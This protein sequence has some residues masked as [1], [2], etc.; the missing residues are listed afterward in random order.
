ML[1]T[2]EGIDASG[3]TTQI[4]LLAESLERQGVQI[5]KTRQPGG[6]VI[7]QKIRKILLDPDNTEMVPETEVLLYMA[8]RIQHIKQVIEPALSLG[9]TVLCDRYHDATM[10]YQGAGR[11]LDL[12]WL[13][14][15]KN[16]MIRVPDLTLW[17]DISVEESQDRLLKRNMSQNVENCRLEREEFAFFDRIRTAYNSFAQQESDRFVRLDATG[18][19]S[20]I[21]KE[22]ESIVF[23]RLGK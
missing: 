1:I 12:S 22:V 15:I 21:Q 9:K 13:D 7:G 17:F 3:K 10:A 11:Q 23:S 16:N 19:I 6:T 20:S 4:D 5:I 14:P 8:D 2:F 18:E